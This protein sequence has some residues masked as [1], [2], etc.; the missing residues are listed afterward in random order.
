MSGDG[1]P[2][3][4]CRYCGRARYEH[5]VLSS[6][7][8]DLLTGRLVCPTSLFEE[9]AEG[10]EPEAE[11]A[12]VEVPAADD[13]PE[14][15][16]LQA[17]L[18]T[19]GGQLY[20]RLAAAIAEALEGTGWQVT[21]RRRT[22]RELEEA[23]RSEALSRGRAP[24]DVARSLLQSLLADAGRESAY[25]VSDGSAMRGLERATEILSGGAG[26]AEV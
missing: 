1:L 2:E 15:P 5:V 9:L 18:G 24:R 14:R 4:R 16:P 12:L 11:A 19:G 23:L 22:A 7:A 25:P 17:E 8:L 3:A 21:D 10:A 6:G 20:G 26:D 13:A